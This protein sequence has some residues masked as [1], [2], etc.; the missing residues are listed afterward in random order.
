MKDAKGHGSNAR[1][2]PGH[3]YHA[4]TNDQLRYIVKDASEAAQAT[5]GQSMYDPNSSKRQDTE[6]KYLD[7]VNDAST[8]LSYRAR[9]GLSDHPDDV[10]ARTLATGP[11]SA[12]APTHDGMGGHTPGDYFSRVSAK[13][14]RAL[15]VYGPH[16][17]RETAAA[18]AL[19]R[20]PK[21]KTVSTYRHSGLDIRWHNR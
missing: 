11:K 5:R 13:N 12:P 20:H 21:A 17:D 6:G 9:G 3:P 15:G 2:I 4:K 19:A 14:G 7:Q 10:A 18:D 8:V 16:H 1:P